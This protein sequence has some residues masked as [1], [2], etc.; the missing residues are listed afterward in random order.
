MNQL[1]T[2]SKTYLESNMKKRRTR[3]KMI[4]AVKKAAEITEAKAAV[5]SPNM[6]MPT[7]H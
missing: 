3:R 1:K 6:V 7:I 5:K 4:K 2:G